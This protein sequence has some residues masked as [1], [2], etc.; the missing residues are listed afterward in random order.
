VVAYIRDA[1]GD[2]VLLAW[3]VARVT[4]CRGLVKGYLH[5]VAALVGI[6]IVAFTQGA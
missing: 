3:F 4:H 6:H 1:T 5:N 2:S